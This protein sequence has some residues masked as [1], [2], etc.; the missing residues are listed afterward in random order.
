L[1]YL[2]IELF[3]KDCLLKAAVTIKTDFKFTAGQPHP[4]MIILSSREI[5]I[6]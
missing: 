3:G 5:K 6:A 1:F 4:G 2:R